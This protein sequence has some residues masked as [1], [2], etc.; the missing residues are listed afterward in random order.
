MTLKQLALGGLVAFGLSGCGVATLPTAPAKVD[1]PPATIGQS[2][3]T[4][5]AS[6]VTSASPPASGAQPAAGAQAAAN[7]GA[8]GSGAQAASTSGTAGSDVAVAQA[9]PASASAAPAG[10]PV[11]AAPAVFRLPPLT[12]IRQTLN[13]CGPASVAEVLHYW[14]VERTQGQ[15]MAALRPDGNSR[16]MMPYPV[17]AYTQGLGMS[18]LMGIGG[19]PAIIKGLVANGFPVIVAQNVSLQEPIAHYREI[20][21]WDDQRQVFISTD[22]YLGPNHEI[23][24][25]EFDQLWKRGNQRFMVIY[26]PAKQA[27][28]NAVLKSVNWDKNAVY[29]A[30]LEKNL[31]GDVTPAG[32]G[33]PRAGGFPGFP[34]SPELNVAWDNIQLGHLDAAK[35]ALAQAPK[36]SRTSQMIDWLN[37]AMAVAA[38]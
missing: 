6:P 26:P 15:T 9:S 2:N 29:Q 8:A 21:G 22:T 13:N 4:S 36:T 19:T 3:M 25:P 37:Q 10:P 30:D 14:G 18:S 28:L 17:P 23:S 24:Y 27:L 31:H 1:A 32:P 35:A 11:T 5:P 33:E 20:E 38:A 12:Y 7:S 34:G 16:G